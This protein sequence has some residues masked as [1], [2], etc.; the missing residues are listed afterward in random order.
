M[1]I[2]KKWYIILIDLF[3]FLFLIFFLKRIANFIYFLS[4][5][6]FVFAFTLM[7]GFLFAVIIFDLYIKHFPIK[8]EISK[9]ILKVYQI[10]K[11]VSIKKED[12]VSISCKKKLIILPTQDLFVIKTKIGAIILKKFEYKKIDDFIYKLNE[13][14]DETY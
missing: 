6:D 10:G 8:I 1:I 14:I 12:I 9:S 11:V 2:N 3:V 4:K 5:N 13:M 7:L